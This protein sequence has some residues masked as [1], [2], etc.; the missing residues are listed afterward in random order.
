MK[1]QQGFT[2][3]ELM[4]VVVIIAI[5]AAIAIPSQI[6]HQKKARRAVAKS[7]MM[8][9]QSK[10]E[11]YFMD[12]KV[13]APDLTLLRYPAASLTIDDKGKNVPVADA[14]YRVEISMLVDS[15]SYII[16][17]TPINAQSSDECGVLTLNN[18]GQKSP[19]KCW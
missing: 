14:F 15:I 16:Q 17:A 19:S 9:I 10:E 11:N 18:I 8:E 13:Y 1:Q 12:Y 4:I 6:N 3:V 2:L 5:L 7:V